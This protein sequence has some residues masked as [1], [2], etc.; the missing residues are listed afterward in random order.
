MITES[1]VI[2]PREHLVVE[3]FDDALVIWDE[4][5]A[6]LHRLD[7]F[8]AVVWDQLDGRRTIR[9]VTEGIAEDIPPPTDGLGEAVME[10]LQRL[11]TEG[12]V[13]VEPA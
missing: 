11:T 2:A 9:E 13:S 5:S 4:H 1:S 8:A 10:L 7:L 12:L 3:G 6:K